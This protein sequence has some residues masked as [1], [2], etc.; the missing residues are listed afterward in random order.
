MKDK[1]NRNGKKTLLFRLTNRLI[2]ICIF[3]SAA[4]LFIIPF[5][6]ENLAIKEEAKVIEKKVNIDVASQM[7]VFTQKSFYY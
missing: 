7:H 6:I 4:S 2:A 1:L 5:G 3:G